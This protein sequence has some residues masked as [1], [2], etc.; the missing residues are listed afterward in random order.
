[1]ILRCGQCGLRLTK[2]LSN[3]VLDHSA[4]GIT[5]SVQKGHATRLISDP[6][7]YMSINGLLGVNEEDV[8]EENLKFQYTQQRNGCCGHIAEL[9]CKSMHSVGRTYYDCWICLKGFNADNVTI[10]CGEKLSAPVQ[11]G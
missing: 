1:M 10:D 2:N 3:K 7:G 11:S 6:N 4:F 8:V 9:Y 5:V